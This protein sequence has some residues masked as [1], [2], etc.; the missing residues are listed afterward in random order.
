MKNPRKQFL[1]RRELNR[2]LLRYF[3]NSKIS[4][5]CNFVSTTINRLVYEE[6]YS[7]Y[8][9]KQHLG[10]KNRTS[11][12]GCKQDGEGPSEDFNMFSSLVYNACTL[13]CQGNV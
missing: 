9:Y 13:L 1:L 7:D 5:S 12:T 6:Q 10:L 8:S 4:T 2:R 3:E 11:I